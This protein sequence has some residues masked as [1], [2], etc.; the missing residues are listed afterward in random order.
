MAG[1]ALVLED[2]VTLRRPVPA[3]VL[4]CRCDLCAHL[5]ADGRAV[6]KDISCDTEVVRL[7]WQQDGH[8]LSAYILTRYVKRY[9]P[10]LP[11]QIGYL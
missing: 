7:T 6:V 5:V 8:W 3:S 9:V 4:T 1:G 10:T 11:P 2:V